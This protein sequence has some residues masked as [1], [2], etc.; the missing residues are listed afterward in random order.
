MGVIVS[1]LA[2]S[3]SSPF[4]QPSILYAFL[5]SPLAFL[6]RTIHSTFTSSKPFP[7]PLEPPIRVV[8]ISD[9]HTGLA[10]IPDGDLLIHAGDLTNAGTMKELQS[11][12]D[13]LNSLPHK[14]KIAIAGNHDTF[15]DPRSRK[16][17]PADDRDGTLDWGNVRYLQ[18][19]M[20]QIEFPEHAGRILKVYGAPQTPACGGEEF[21]FQYPRGQ[22][23]WSGT[24][25]GDIDILVTHTPPKWYLDLPVGLGCEW[26]LKE[27]WRVKPRLHVF[28]HVHAGSGIAVECWNRGRTAYER[29][30]E[31]PGGFIQRFCN[32]LNWKDLVV[33]VLSDL[34]S[35][36]W[37]PLWGGVERSGIIVNAALMSQ[38]TGTLDNAPK[39]IQ[40]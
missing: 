9:T 37:V 38:A 6:A 13:W 24:I 8:C 19:E 5:T 32:I 10:P 14:H 21:A 17:L 28:G 4:D 40:I 15:L 22:D 26:L 39:T 36:W 3:P 29:I 35:M 11:Q 34:K 27:T 31:R 12:I 23:A 33:M 20:I 25:P 18:H 7:R 2:A 16:T 1:S 30:C